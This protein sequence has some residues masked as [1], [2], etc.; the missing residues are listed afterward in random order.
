MSRRTPSYCLHRAS[1]QAVVRIDGKDHYLGKY[2]SPESRAEYDRLIAEWL[3]NGR[4]LPAATKAGGLTV[5]E[6]L[7]QYWHWA[8]QH[9]RDADGNPSNELA[10]M[11]DALRPLRQ[12][13]GHTAAGSFTSLDLESLQEHLV[14]SGRLSRTTINAR[15]NRIRRMFKWAVRKKLIPVTV[16]Q[17]LQT[18]PGL[19]RGHCEAP[20]P[21]GVKPVPEEHVLATLP[22]LPAPVRAMVEVQRLTGSRAGE[23]MV[24]RAIDL[25]MSDSIWTYRPHRHKNQHRGLDRVIFIGPRAQ[26]IIRPFLTPN[27]EAY[28]FSPRRYVEELHARRSAAR[29]TRRTPS[30]TARQRKARPKRKPAE[31]YNRRSYRV[32]IVRA[33]DKANEERARQGLPLLPRWS[34]LQL[35]HTAATVIRS[36]YDVE[37]SQVVLGHTR[38]ETTQIYAERNLARAA[39]IMAEIG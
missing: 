34:P 27:L 15:V 28:L 25:N 2:G 10:N 16:L 23:V 4:S 38:V 14:R 31:R 39:Q 30:E 21:E 18:V 33:V 19:Q 35:R 17:E 11:K 20:E 12:L 37:A 22:F 9:Y 24:M 8:E 13:F 36:K 1:G 7:L 5:N 3:A 6:V 29:T 26:A 32:A